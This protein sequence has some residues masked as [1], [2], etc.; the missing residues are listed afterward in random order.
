MKRGKKSGGVSDR[1]PAAEDAVKRTESA[2][3][4]K[5]VQQY[6]QKLAPSGVILADVII[7]EHR[8]EV[9]REASED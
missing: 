7:K 1:G 6:F 4:L 8:D 3:A 5:A 2:A 9:K